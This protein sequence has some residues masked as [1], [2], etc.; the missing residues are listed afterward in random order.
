MKSTYKPADALR[1][2]SDKNIDW[3]IAGGWALDLFLGKRSREHEDLD[4]AVLRKDEKQIR[5]LLNGWHLQIGLGEGKLELTPLS[6]DKQLRSNREIVW[7]KPSVDSDW[8]FELLLSKSEHDEWIFKRNE[9]IRLP[10]KE[11]GG[12]TGD[13]VSYL[14]P[15]IVLLFK[16]K[17]LNTKN[18]SDFENVYPFLSSKQKNWLKKSIS[19][20]H[21]SHPWLAQ[22]N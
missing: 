5:N 19:I 16:A 7:C 4:I 14:Q 17:T 12:V 20:V 18:Q 21:P 15:E 2:F 8:A 1:L 22:I 13:G 9:T 10:L 3:W 11:I 6:K